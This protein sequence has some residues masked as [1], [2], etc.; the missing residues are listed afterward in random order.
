M[1]GTYARR[2]QLLWMSGGKIPESL[3]TW[4]WS[5]CLQRLSDFFADDV[6]E[7]YAVIIRKI[8]FFGSILGYFG[9]F[10]DLERIFTKNSDF[11]RPQPGTAGGVAATISH[12]LTTTTPNYYDYY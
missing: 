8:V 4:V 5:A 12:Q 11:P 7:L 2:I 1:C 10:H 6:Q 3:Q 9:H